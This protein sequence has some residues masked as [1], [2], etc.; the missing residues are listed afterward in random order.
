MDSSVMA[1][2][3]TSLVPQSM[4][5]AVERVPFVTAAWTF[6]VSLKGNGR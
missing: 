2:E 5:L 1:E 6:A 3:A 4:V